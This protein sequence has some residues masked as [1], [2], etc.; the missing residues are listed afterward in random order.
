MKRRDFLVGGIASLAATA[1]QAAPRAYMLSGKG[2]NISYTFMLDKLAQR[3]SVPINDIDIQIDP[4]DLT[5]SRV[6][7]SADVTRAKTGLFFATEALKSASVL[8]ARTHPLARFVS[9]KVS[10]G[11]NGTFSNGAMIEGLLTLRGMTHPIRLNASL[12]R[13]AGAAQNDLT[14]LSI[15]LKGTLSR[16][17]FGATGYQDLVADRV[18]MNITADL[19]A[20]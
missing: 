5:R 4:N 19:K 7:V 10:L 17:K 2:A 3:G 6:D 20:I 12:F 13:Q 8:N 15:K 18:E 16:A 1:A 11:P 14:R 9:R